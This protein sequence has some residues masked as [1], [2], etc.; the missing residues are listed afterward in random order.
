MLQRKQSLLMIIIVFSACAAAHPG[1]GQLSLSTGLIS[2]FL[3]PLTGLDH[4]AVLLTVGYIGGKFTGRQRYLLPATFLGLMAVGFLVSHSGVH[5]ASAATTELM[6]SVSLVLAVVLMVVNGIGM[7]MLTSLFRQYI[8]P[9][10]TA[11]ALFH[12]LAHGYE[13]P[14]GASMT[15]FGLG[16]LVASIGLVVSAMVLSRTRVMATTRRA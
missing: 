3:H 5:I 2:G 1:H 11:F 15:G 10:I 9:I 6:I 7:K 12:G 8:L 4:L 13:V 14:Q 16:F